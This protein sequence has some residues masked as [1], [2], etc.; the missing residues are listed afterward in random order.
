[1]Q[2]ERGRE[3][4]YLSKIKEKIISRQTNAN[5]KIGIERNRD[6]NRIEMFC[7]CLIELNNI[8]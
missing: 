8:F 7:N 1:M 5:I 6:V 2:Q 3:T 4:T